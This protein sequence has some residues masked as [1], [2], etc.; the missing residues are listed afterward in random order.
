MVGW[1]FSLASIIKLCSANSINRTEACEFLNETYCLLKPRLDD[2]YPSLNLGGT[3]KPNQTFTIYGEDCFIKTSEKIFISQQTGNIKI[4]LSNCTLYSTQISLDL[5][6]PGA[7]IGGSQNTS[8]LLANGSMISSTNTSSYYGGRVPGSMYCYSGCSNPGYVYGDP[9]LP[10]QS[11]TNGDNQNSRISSSHTLG[12]GAPNSEQY[13]SRGGGRIYLRANSITI[14]TTSA[15]S[16]NGFQGNSAN[17]VQD[18]TNYG[19]TGGTIFITAITLKINLNSATAYQQNKFLIQAEGSNFSGLKDDYV[20]GGG[21]RIYLYI[22]NLKNS[23]DRLD[24]QE[25]ISA[26][27]Y[28]GMTTFD[29]NMANSGTIY[30]NYVLNQTD[31]LIVK[32]SH[33]FNTTMKN[34]K[35]VVPTYFHQ[36]SPIASQNL[37]IQLNNSNYVQYLN[38]GETLVE[39]ALIKTT[40]SI[41]SWNTNNGANSLQINLK[42][43]SVND[44]SIIMVNSTGSN[45]FTVDG[46]A[47]ISQNS[48][49]LLQQ[50]MVFTF[51][52]QVFSLT[53]NSTFQQDLAIYQAKS[54]LL[55][56]LTVELVSQQIIISE[57]TI[58][59]QKLNLSP[60]TSLSITS[61]IISNNGFYSC[62][63]QTLVSKEMD[64]FLQDCRLAMVNLT[65][66]Q[67]YR[68]NFIGVTKQD[69]N[70]G[71]SSP[72]SQISFVMINSTNKLLNIANTKFNNVGYFLA[73]ADTFTLDADSVI[74]TSQTGCP[75]TNPTVKSDFPKFLKVCKVEGGSNIGRGSFGKDINVEL[76]K[77]L[78]PM[79]QSTDL[80]LIPISVRKIKF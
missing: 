39:V 6:R 49:I 19:G 14:D 27:G 46:D 30:I 11:V 69:P 7:M 51:I 34:R 20:L 25:S 79:P 74:S 67:N 54:Q 15:I 5:I 78:M 38:E 75:T 40:N 3:Q 37:T 18:Q 17:F 41:F 32:N 24:I 36:S 76:C 63:D 65:C 29:Y 80:D 77:Y 66:Y 31:Y 44:N 53:E 55:S 56:S 73:Y 68:N 45:V 2:L 13:Y 50:N 59:V 72:S 22:F 35:G 57:S 42:S 10:V 47:M 43:L 12:S 58:S 9:I 8:I 26:S 71:P 21:G 52:S 23:S 62:P 16:A 48:T 1:C 61:S 60:Q 70:S 4:I 64:Q 28:G 33:P